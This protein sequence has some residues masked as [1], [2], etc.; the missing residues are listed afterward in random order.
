M[1][2]FLF[3]DG[4][5]K[6]TLYSQKDDIYFTAQSI[7]ELTL[8]KARSIFSAI[9]LVPWSLQTRLSQRQFPLSLTY[10]HV[11]PKLIICK[12][13]LLSSKKIYNIFHISCKL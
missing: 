5:I 2:H 4:A 10:N 6:N 1:V 11:I 7:L 12:R 3:C 13:T 9:L 8:N